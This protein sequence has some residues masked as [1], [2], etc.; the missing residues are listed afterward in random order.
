MNDP[1]PIWELAWWL[2]ML[3]QGAAFQE[4][5]GTWEWDYMADWY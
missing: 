4:F 5:D 1:D 3:P 2:T